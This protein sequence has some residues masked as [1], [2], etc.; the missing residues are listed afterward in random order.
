VTQAEKA[1]Q[2]LRTPQPPVP[3][4]PCPSRSPSL[5]ADSPLDMRV[6]G[7]M[8][9]QLLHLLGPVPYDP[10]VGHRQAH[11]SGCTPGRSAA[12]AVVPIVWEARRVTGG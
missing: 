1:A 7:E 12:L 2:A 4:P 3:Q 10:K 5:A 6:K 8:V 9:S 11:A